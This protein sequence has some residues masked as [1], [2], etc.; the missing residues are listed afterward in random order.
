[1]N[2]LWSEE[3]TQYIFKIHW[4]ES[5]E[6]FSFFFDFTASVFSEII[7]PLFTQLRL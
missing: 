7:L 1:M 4:T 5:E 2:I 3:L 6:F